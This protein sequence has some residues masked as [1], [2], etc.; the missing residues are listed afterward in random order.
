MTRLFS[1]RKPTISWE[2]ALELACILSVTAVM[3]A[4]GEDTLTPATSAAG[5]DTAQAYEALSVSLQAC[6]DQQDACTTAAAGD[7]AKLA[8][9]D[10]DAAA[11]KQKT[12]AAAAHARENLARDTNSCWKRCGHSDDDAGAVSSDDD[13]G[14]EDLPGCVEHHTPRVPSCVKGLLGCLHDAGF[15]KGD[16][17]RDELVACIQEADVCFHDQ[18][19][20]K[21]A[22]KRGRGRGRGDEA[23]KGAAGSVAVAGAPAP[24][25]AGSGGSKSDDDK[26]RSGSNRGRR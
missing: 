21:R 1:T 14:T 18:F 24:A 26:G 16:A 10:S 5:D 22:E 13:G 4:C 12:E 17:S 9:C 3:S 25:A 23:G 2:R 20:A 7:P 11:C 19:A 15:K 6:E 8:T